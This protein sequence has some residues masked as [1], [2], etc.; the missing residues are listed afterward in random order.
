[1]NMKS[2]FLVTTLLAVSVA[3]V[4]QNDES[5]TKDVKEFIANHVTLEDVVRNHYKFRDD[6]VVNSAQAHVAGRSLLPF[7]RSGCEVCTWYRFDTNGI[8]TCLAKC[9][10]FSAGQGVGGGSF[11]RSLTEGTTADAVMAD[12]ADD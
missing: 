3:V 10:G 11:R 5:A 12:G 7:E 6:S 2:P 1:M 9:T 8:R 4:I